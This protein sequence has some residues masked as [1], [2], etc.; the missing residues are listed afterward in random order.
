MNPKDLTI[1]EHIEEL[2]KRLFIVAV[3]FA[4]ALFGGF[5]VAKPLIKYL[6]GTAG[7][8]GI[9]L[10]VFDVT[11]PLTIYFQ[12]IFLVAFILSSPLLMYQL[13]AFVSPGLRE[14]ERRATLSYIPYAFLLFLVG[15]SFSYFWLFPYVMKAMMT[16]SNEM[17]F[18]QTIG[19]YEYF[20]FLFKLVIPFGILFQL[21]IVMLFLSRIGLVTPMLLARIRKYA[22]F[23]LFVCAAVIAP[24]ELTSHL[25]VSVP[26]FVLYE[27]SLMISRIGYRKYLK[28][29]ELRL[30]EE[31]EAE[32]KRQIEEALALQ[33][34]QIEELNQ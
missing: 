1:I 34:R 25:M 32:E 18:Q 28:S 26:L 3:F 11:T 31:Q 4:L 8:Y 20:S 24:P 10:N 6:Q 2:R 21:P 5:F 23:A 7:D 12:V 9:T 14:V 19:I 30:K 29:E 22:Y 27:I 15:L 16:L 17:D 13:W 33:Q